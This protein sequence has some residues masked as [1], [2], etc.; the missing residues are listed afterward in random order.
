MITLPGG[1][2]DLLSTLRD[3]LEAIYL[4]GSRGRG[5]ARPDSDIDILIV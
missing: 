5:E 3:E 2:Q 4:C 1:L